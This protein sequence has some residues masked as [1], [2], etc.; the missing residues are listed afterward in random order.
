MSQTLVLRVWYAQVD[1]VSTQLFF[2]NDTVQDAIDSTAHRIG[3]S[4]PEYGLRLGHEWLQPQTVLSSL[5]LSPASRTQVDLLPRL[6]SVL[7]SIA[8]RP[9]EQTLSVD[10]SRPAREVAASLARQLGAASPEIFFLGI[11][12]TSAT[13]TIIN[14]EAILCNSLP[15]SGD[16]QPVL[17]LLRALGPLRNRCLSELAAADIPHPSLY[18]VPQHLQD[19]VLWYRTRSSERGP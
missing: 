13:P 6:R 3:W 17:V 4:P 15:Q 14:S 5:G 2:S 11:I 9:G 18:R 7:V 1:T 16:T 19:E 12:E 8:G 10:Q